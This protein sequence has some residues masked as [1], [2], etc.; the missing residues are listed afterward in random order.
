MIR[1]G[2]GGEGGITTGNKGY[3]KMGRNKA[4]EDRREKPIHT[5]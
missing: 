3:A 5:L 4:R 2:G 1:N